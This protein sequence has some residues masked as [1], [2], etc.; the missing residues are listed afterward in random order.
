M[1]QIWQSIA[2]WFQDYHGGGDISHRIHQA[3]TG[4]VFY[5]RMFYNKAFFLS[6]IIKLL[7]F[8]ATVTL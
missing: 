7:L 1:R 4:E 2:Q 5:S 6:D 8:A 3:E